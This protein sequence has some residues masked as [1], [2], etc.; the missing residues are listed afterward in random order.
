M[1]LCSSSW[2]SITTCH[3]PAVHKG[4]HGVVVALQQLLDTGAR[5]PICSLPALTPQMLL[6]LETCGMH[7]W[8]TCMQC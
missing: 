5:T 2:R 3:L 8:T 1:P 6:V 4:S 7:A